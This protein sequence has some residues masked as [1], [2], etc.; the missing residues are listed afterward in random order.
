MTTTSQQ[1]NRPQTTTPA[2]EESATLVSPQGS[3]R[4]TILRTTFG[5]RSST[6]S[7]QNPSPKH[8]ENSA[9]Q[10]PESSM[11]GAEV[12]LSE[13]KELLRKVIDGAV[14][15]DDETRVAAVKRISL[16]TDPQTV[17]ALMEHSTNP[18][19]PEVVQTAAVE[20]LSIYSV[21][22][23]DAPQAVSK[24]L[25]E[26]LSNSSLPI[27]SRDAA[28]TIL[29]DFHT[30]HA[31]TDPELTR[32]V[33]TA[34]GPLGSRD[35]DHPLEVANIRSTAAQLAGNL[36]APIALELVSA[37]HTPRE[38]RE[39]MAKAVA[40][41]AEPS[42]LPMIIKAL[43]AEAA[44]TKDGHEAVSSSLSEALIQAGSHQAY[45]N[46]QEIFNSAQNEQAISGIGHWLI[47]CSHERPSE[48]FDTILKHPLCPQDARD[49]L[50]SLMSPA[51]TEANVK[52]LYE[53]SRKQLSNPSSQAPHIGLSAT[54]DILSE[55]DTL[56]ALQLA[57]E[58]ATSAHTSRDQYLPLSSALRLMTDHDLRDEAIEAARRI[59]LSSKCFPELRVDALLFLHYQDEKVFNDARLQVTEQP[60]TS[61][62]LDSLE[63]R[64][65]ISQTKPRT[66]DDCLNTLSSA[67]ALTPECFEA[68]EALQ[69]S[70]NP[71][72]NE[73][74]GY[75]LKT[76]I[77]PALSIAIATTLA[78]RGD[79]T[80]VTALKAHGDLLEF[81][82]EVLSALAAV[83][84]PAATVTVF[85]AL[86]DQNSVKALAARHAIKELVDLKGVDGTSEQLRAAADDAS[87][88][89]NTRNAI[90]AYV[91]HISTATSLGI[92]HP[93]RFSPATLEAIVQGRA[94]DSTFEQKP[95]KEALL[96]F[97]KED[98][99]NVFSNMDSQI[100]TLI[101]HGYKI[102]FFECASDSEL[103]QLMAERGKTGKAADLLVL[104][105]HG[106]REQ[107]S[108][109]AQD[110]AQNPFASS[111]KTFDVEDVA[112]FKAAG[113]DRALREGGMIAIISCLAGN[114]ADTAL[115]Q[116]NALREI[117]PQAR[118]KGVFAPRYSTMFEGFDFND[119]GEV[120]DVRFSVEQYRANNESST[121]LSDK[122][123]TRA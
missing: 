107:L 42:H 98:E 56:L 105:G 38:L 40:W 111:D 8:H 25:V 26:I 81:Q 104:G 69:E 122:T 120:V 97:P 24:H 73:E 78:L 48:C 62:I 108:L 33:A 21:G 76:T 86:S 80:G 79:D 55:R 41:L 37:Q 30:R 116:A 11:S 72:L 6:E 12:H 60:Q 99:T 1:T 87:T 83:D 52:Y 75:L 36:G 61:S 115:N 31:L 46:L 15:A 85:Q 7:K 39:G 23:G 53:D 10:S 43:R 77:D 4:Q 45:G 71:R 14:A 16:L 57:Q 94:H 109:G 92:E 34:R 82:G 91:K 58:I 106:S 44:L 95:G 123:L 119:K 50:I 3:D 103:K 47:K 35:S 74:L 118:E 84:N 27:A 67:R 64:L 63:T 112:A 90:T 9:R 49:S 17:P 2:K 18:A 102:R 59:C 51:L 29:N 93:N 110:P 100:R 28:A 32:L 88:D 101:D 121:P 70:E 13:D 65:A 22:S 66:D 68:L 113:A 20:A 117:F 54:L 114:G 89:E 5:R 19:L 96:V